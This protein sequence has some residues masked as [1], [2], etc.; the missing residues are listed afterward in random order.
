MSRPRPDRDIIERALAVTNRTH[1]QME[2]YVREEWEA[3]LGATRVAL[4][5]VRRLWPL[6]QDALTER[7]FGCLE[8]VA[9]D[10][11]RAYAQLD[12]MSEDM[13]GKLLN[14]ACA[15]RLDAAEILAVEQ[16]TNPG[17]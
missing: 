11:G 4:D 13:L 3:A 12:G 8:G 17:V 1:T 14:D 15:G 7:D 9:G 2:R 10:L 5:A 16:Q 6:E